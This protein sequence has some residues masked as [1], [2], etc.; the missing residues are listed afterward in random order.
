MINW[1]GKPEEKKSIYSRNDNVTLPVS[2]P[3]PQQPSISDMFLSGFSKLKSGIGGALSGIDNFVNN[4]ALLSTITGPHEMVRFKDQSIDPAL[5]MNQFRNPIG[6]R[7]SVSSLENSIY[8]TKPISWEE[9][10]ANMKQLRKR[11]ID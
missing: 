1:S 2:I 11:G 10:M 5:V 9:K 3:P 6:P 4:P 8:N 7:Q